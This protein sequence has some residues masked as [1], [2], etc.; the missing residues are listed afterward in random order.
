MVRRPRQR[1]A[2]RL[3]QRLKAERIARRWTQEAAAERC[4]L[5]AR[6]YQK[7]EAGELNATLATLERLSDAFGVDAAELIRPT[8]QT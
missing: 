5:V 4:G 2:R 7:L 1:L 3:G 6:H 8:T